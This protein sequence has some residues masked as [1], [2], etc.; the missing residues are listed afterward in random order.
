MAGALALVASIAVSGTVQASCE[1]DNRV[2]ASEARSLQ[3]TWDNSCEVKVWGKCMMWSSTFSARNTF[4][5]QGKVV[6]KI[7][8]KDKADRTWHLTNSAWNDGS[9]DANK[10]N[11]IY[12]CKDLSASGQCD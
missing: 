2:A 7:D 11:G 9:E 8:I 6:A 3:A 10:V 1:D 12:C 4:P 5:S